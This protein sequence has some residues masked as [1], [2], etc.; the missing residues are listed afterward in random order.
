MWSG[1]S[2]ATITY[3]KYNGDTGEAPGADTYPKGSRIVVKDKEGLGHE[4]AVFLGW[5]EHNGGGLVNSVA[6]LSELGE[7]KKPGST[8]VLNNDVD[9]YAV[10]AADSKGGGE[11]G[12]GPDNAADCMQVFYD[13]GE[14]SNSQIS[15]PTDTTEYKEGDTIVLRDLSGEGFVNG[16]CSKDRRT[17]LGWKLQGSDDSTLYKPG[18]TIKLDNGNYSKYAGKTFEAQWE[19]TYKIVYNGNDNTDGTAPN[20]AGGYAKDQ[21]FNLQNRSGLVRNGAVFMGWSLTKTAL[22]TTKPKDIYAEGA[23]VKLDETFTNKAKSDDS[24]A[25]GEKVITLYAVW[26][27]DEYSVDPNA[28]KVETPD[29][30]PDYEQVIY[31]VNDT[32]H[33]G[34]QQLTPPHDTNR[35]EQGASV[36]VRGMSDHS[37][38]DHKAHKFIGWS[39]TPGATT[40]DQVNYDPNGA[41]DKQKFNMPEGGMVLYAVWQDEDITIATLKYDGNGATAGSTPEPKVYDL[42]STAETLDQNTGNLQRDGAVWVGWS[43][44]QHDP[45]TTSKGLDYNVTPPITMDSDKTVFALWAA[46]EYGSDSNDD[47]KPDPDKIP[48]YYQVKYDGN[49][50]E[51]EVKELPIDG[52]KYDLSD[53]KTVTV[54]SGTPTREG[55]RFDGWSLNAPDGSGTNPTTDN[56]LYKASDEFTKNDKLDVLYAIWSKGYT[57]SYDSNGGEGSIESV[58]GKYSGESADVNKNEGGKIHR[59]DHKF[60]GWSETQTDVVKT[61]TDYVKVQFAGET[62]KFTDGDITLY[63]VWAEDSLTPGDDS[64]GDEIADFY[65]YGYFP[66]KPDGASGDVKNMPDQ[67]TG[68]FVPDSMIP[69][70]TTVPTLDGYNFVGWSLNSDGKDGKPNIVTGSFSKNNSFDKLYAIWAGS[71]KLTYD[72]NDGIGGPAD[73][74]HIASG[75]YVTFDSAKPTKKDCVFLGWTTNESA[76]G[77]IYGDGTAL[78]EMPSGLRIERD[79]TVYAVWASDS[80]NSATPDPGT[81]EVTPKPNDDVAD[82]YQAR[83]RGRGCAKCSDRHG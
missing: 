40:K 29:N 12:N 10:W 34:T 66:N 38:G 81:P 19:T 69:L 74:D 7:I 1:L 45:I 48:D 9:L 13:K 55:Y 65:Q 17:F 59:D 8:L 77:E 5:T 44:A 37:N 3:N 46:D 14:C 61:Y 42:N 15:V 75:T 78:P 73:R 18:D 27:Q 80:F 57:L 36:T 50:G 58:T 67:P 68:T 16:M 20:G 52:G 30:I 62:V 76:K 47:G 25:S 6:E 23:H 2:E 26:A 21:E 35:Y 49:A 70:S 22:Q 56:A 72:K 32:E 54:Q 43:M 33:E 24:G 51:D 60:L 41:E 31:F 64:K 28:E 11:K 82:L 79:T 63:A 71:F 39:E 4:K 83:W 53:N